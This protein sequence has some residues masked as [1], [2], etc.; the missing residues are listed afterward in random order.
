[1][2]PFLNYLRQEV[3]NVL[4][5]QSLG[6]LR[7]PEIFKAL[8][9]K[10]IYVIPNFFSA[11]Q[12]AELRDE[13]DRL[14]QKHENKIWS[15]VLGAD[16]RIFGAEEV[17]D[18]FNQYFNNQ[19]I[20]DVILEFERGDKIKGF[21]MAARLDYKPGNLGSGNG[22]HRDSAH[23][24]QTKSILYLSNA[25]LENGP[26]EYIVGSQ[27]PCAYMRGLLKKSYGL[28]Q[29][30]FTEEEITRYLNDFPEYKAEKFPASEGTL[31]FADTRG[32]HRGSPIQK[33]TRYAA[34][35]YFF[36]RVEPPQHLLDQTLKPLIE[37]D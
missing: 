2:K 27:T 31:I 16:R 18:G 17:S 34:T 19:F 32:I 37:L 7:H 36:V 25:S 26:F 22:W 5:R 1:M 35:N 10:G 20:R 21:T 6:K 4:K 23:Y 29:F 33:G 30:R 12:C 24:S 13:I 14:I 8:K 15:D 28:E 11:S 3:L 9:T